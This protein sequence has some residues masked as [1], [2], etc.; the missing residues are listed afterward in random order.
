[1]STVYKEEEE[2]DSCQQGSVSHWITLQFNYVKLNQ[3]F[4]MQGSLQ[5]ASQVKQAGE[6][7]APVGDIT[8]QQGEVW[9]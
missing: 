9:K 1:M 3:A 2:T 4:T 8:V 5:A 6:R 7:P